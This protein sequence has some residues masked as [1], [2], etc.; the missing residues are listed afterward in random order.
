[1]FNALIQIILGS[2]RSLRIGKMMCALAK[3][4]SKSIHSE[5]EEPCQLV[6]YLTNRTPAAVDNSRVGPRKLC[7]AGFSGCGWSYAIC[8]EDTEV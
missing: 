7:K 2:D 4:S 6:S 3:K 5:G 8:A 1:M